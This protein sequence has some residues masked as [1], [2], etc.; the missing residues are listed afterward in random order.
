MIGNGYNWINTLSKS[1]ELPPTTVRKKVRES[2]AYKIAMLDSLEHIARIQFHENLKFNDYYRMF[3]NKMSFQELK[4]VIPHLEDVQDLLDGNYVNTQLKHYD[5]IGG[6]IRDI[7]GRYG[8]L[9]DKFNVVETGDLAMNDW[10]THKTKQLQTML[11][12]KINAEVELFLAEQGLTMDGKQFS[13]QEEQQQFMQQLQQA[14]AKAMTPEREKL[15]GSTYKP[16]SVQWGEVTLEKDT[17]EQNLYQKDKE[18]LTDKCLSGRWFREY[19]IGLDNYESNN[20]SAKNTF[21]SKEMDA[22]FPQDSE[23]IG[24]LHWMTPAEVIKKWHHELNSEEQK[25]ILGGKKDWKAFVGEGFEG[26]LESNLKHNF[27]KP[28]RAPF[29]NYLDYSYYLNLQDEVGLPMGEQTSFNPDGTQTVSDR[30]L[31]RYQNRNAAAYKDYANIMRSDFEHRDDLCE[32]TEGYIR[33]YELFG[34]LTYEDENGALVTEEVTEDILDDFLKE[35]GIKQ[36]K[37]ETIS[38]IITS[39]PEVDTIKWV[40]R[41]VSYEYL[42]INTGNA[43]KPLY[44]YF[45]P[46]Q[47]QIKGEH[48]FDIK[49]PVT[50]FIGRGLAERIMPF[51]AAYNLTMNQIYNL[52]EKE[53]GIFFLMD[54]S[55]IPSEIDG[56]GD[57]EEALVSM[58]NLAKDIGL[59]PVQTSGDAQKNQN[60]FNQFTTHNL[61]YAGQVQYRLQLA[62]TYKRLAYEQIG[63]NPQMS[64]QPSKYETAEGIRTNTEVTLAQ[65]SQIFDEFSESRQ[66]SLELHLSV[67]QYAQSNKKDISLQYT[68]DDATIAW[69]TITDPSLPI[70]T[71]GLLPSKDNRKRKQLEAY[72]AYLMNTNTIN[73]DFIEVAKLMYSDT[74]TEILDVAKQAEITRKKRDEEQFQ[75]EQQL[76]DRKAQGDKALQDDKFAKDMAKLDKESQTKI[77]VASLTATGRAADKEADPTYIETIE[78]QTQMNVAKLNQ[79]GN[80]QE[81]D[82]IKVENQKNYQEQT[83]AQ[84]AQELKLKAE[85]LMEKRKDRESKEFIA[86]VNKN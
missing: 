64:M 66:K 79:M 29:R 49:L 74:M 17:L 33:M 65:L 24:R 20:W 83:I 69:L 44:V 70:R 21:F 3:E 55:L 43:P 11:S 5:L 14:R 86:T 52:L 8:D 72:K 81:L 9:Q 23:Y 77:Y 73:A 57:A 1:D 16:V 22:K 13:S 37:K 32:V 58:R 7:V 38:D 19:R 27:N 56:W 84:K 34:F 54:V 78:Q 4:D 12:E 62:E 26:S 40:Y 85:A 67:A 39:A 15:A 2:E 41:P 45:R 10:K 47:H 80:K 68:R 25:D 59:M 18:S 75:R 51:Q 53:V 36:I 50:G 60:N 82:T 6:I 76:I 71:L 31:P 48:M 35:K 46:C 61:S 30:F 28:T 63:S 42:K